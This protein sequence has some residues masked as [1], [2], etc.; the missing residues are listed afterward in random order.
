MSSK[1]EWRPVVGYEESYMVSNTG[2]VMALE[3]I[4]LLKGK[5][6]TRKQQLLTPCIMRNYLCVA[7]SKNGVRHNFGVHRL[8]AM[9][10]IKNPDKENKTQVNHINEIKTDN[11]AENLEWV[12][13][14]ENT[15]HGT[16][17]ERRADKLRL[18]VACCS[19]TGELIKVFRGCKEINE[20]L[21]KKFG[22]TG[23][24]RCCKQKQKT[25][26]GYTWRFARK[27]Y[28][29]TEEQI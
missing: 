29:Q 13:P 28:E 21:G 27:D 26:Y 25:A 10:F 5:E 20:F 19:L 1:E 4:R 14:K 16:G 24:Y 9:A 22:N 17:I 11:R 15:T 23:V 3:R 2:K 18:D 8:V 12:T 6:F 7:L